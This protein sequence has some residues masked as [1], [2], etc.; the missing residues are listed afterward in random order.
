[1]YRLGI[2]LRVGGAAATRA[3][4]SAVIGGRFYG[5][6]SGLWLRDGQEEQ[7]PL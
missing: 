4:A 1:M 7:V 6:H 5:Q 3:S 2:W